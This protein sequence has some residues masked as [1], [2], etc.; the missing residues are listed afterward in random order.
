M[1]NY[2]MEYCGKNRIEVEIP[3][4]FYFSEGDVNHGYVIEDI[5]KNQFL[6]IPSG[7]TSDGLYVRGFWI[8]RF[9]ISMP[10]GKTPRSIAGEYPI[11]NI[12]YKEAMN[13]AKMMNA[14]LLQK[15]QYNRICMWLVETGGA[16]FEEVFIHGN[17]TIGNYSKP[18]VLK[19]TGSNPLWMRNR[20]DG[21]W[22]GSFIWTAEHSELYD[23]YRVIRGGFNDALCEK[24]FSPPINRGWANPQ[25]GSYQIA[26]RVFFQDT[27]DN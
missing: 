11:V 22:G 9:E 17:N 6:R 14:S 23:H 26:L 16:T 18:F 21:F 25:K 7:F 19:K 12:N 27:L 24:E 20:L 2:F 4:G 1:K 15:E 3:T 5:E 13:I 8:S 10:N